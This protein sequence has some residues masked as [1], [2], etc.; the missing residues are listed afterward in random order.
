MNSSNFGCLMVVKQH[1]MKSLCSV[2][3]PPI[4]SLSLVSLSVC[5]SICPLLTF[6]K[7]GS[8]FFSDF[9]HDDSWPWDLVTEEARLRIFTIFLSLDH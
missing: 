4:K 2:Q 7:I 8:L 1:P 5:P 3:Q 9:V 6:I